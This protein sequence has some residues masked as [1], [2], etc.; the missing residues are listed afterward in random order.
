VGAT[1]LRAPGLVASSLA[2]LHETVAIQHGVHRAHRRRPDHRELADQLV[3][4]FEATGLVALVDLVPS[5]PGDPELA[6]QRSHLLALEEPG[7][8]SEARLLGPK[9]GSLRLCQKR[10]FR[11]GHSGEIAL[12]EGSQRIVGLFLCRCFGRARPI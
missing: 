6:A 8:E 11:P 10:L 2:A 9:V 5:D 7:H 12:E 4:A 1:E 3:Q